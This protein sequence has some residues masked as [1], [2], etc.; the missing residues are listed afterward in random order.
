MAS[1]QQMNA[2]AET[3]L[4]AAL[5]HPQCAGGSTDLVSE[6]VVSL[7]IALEVE[8][9]QSAVAAGE[10]QTG[11]RRLE[12]VEVIL[13]EGYPWIAPFFFLRKDFPRNLHHLSSATVHAAPMPCLVDGDVNEFFTSYPLL[14][15]GILAMINQ[16][17][18]WLARAARG[19]LSNAVHGW[20][21]I[22][23]NDARHDI[24][25]DAEMIR[26]RVGTKPGWFV[27]ESRFYR[28]GTFTESIRS[29][30]ESFVF[31]GNKLNTLSPTLENR[32]NLPFDATTSTEPVKGHTVT[33]VLYPGTDSVLDKVLPDTVSTIRELRERAV[34]LG[35]AAPF[36]AF[37]TRLENRLQ[38]YCHPSPITIGVLFCVKRPHVL[39]DRSSDLELIPY[40]FD[41]ILEQGR[42]SLFAPVRAKD[43]AAARQIDDVSAALLHRVS[44]AQT[45]P[46]VSLIGCGSVGSKIAFHLA[47]SGVT[48]TSVT[49]NKYI[50]PH[51]LARHALLE[52]FSI[53]KA[54]VLVEELER[55]DQRPS[56][57]VRDVASDLADP[58]SVS[59]F[60]PEGTG[61]VINTTASLVVRERLSAIPVGDV[62]ARLTEV[63]LFGRGKCAVVL[64]E[65]AGR[66]PN[67]VDLLAWLTAHL[68][69]DERDLMFDPQHGLTQVQIGDGCGS[70]TMPMTDARLSAM[71]AMATEEIMRVASAPEDGGQV[72]I[73]VIGNDGLSTAWRRMSV[74]PFIQIPV[75]GGDWTLRLSNDVDRRIREETARFP[76][77]ETGGLLIGSCSARLRTVS[78]VDIINAPPDSERTPS[79]FVLGTQ[80][81]KAAVKARHV[82]SGE[83]LFDI[84]TWHSHLA[85]QGPSALDLKTAVEIAAERSPPAILLIRT[86]NGYH[87]VMGERRA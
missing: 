57:I 22:L 41:L 5:G 54:Q 30:V 40:V 61:L 6:Q 66:S 72:A 11:V 9:S 52:R 63:V 48:I 18:L 43:V 82:A 44:G 29:R 7:T 53:P 36:N 60:V 87:A 49:D 14:E 31:V 19:S 42:M 21:A 83:S 73:G 34:D 78:I 23:R 56:A 80:G 76:A 16:M 8:M 79:L 27:L 74:E 25:C 32:K 17:C 70:L 62:S 12:R 15:S 47:R 39:M 51:N 46:P 71:A 38:G 24:I 1:E 81:L 26:K 84:G 85:E 77:V 69:D 35:C 45:I 58:R 75:Q 68:T 65:G 3:F 59:A 20:E 2:H 13:S 86:P 50:R 64:I 67:L 10:S 37:L 4:R 28:F 33:V 55:L